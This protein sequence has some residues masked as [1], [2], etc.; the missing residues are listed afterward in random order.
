MRPVRKG[1]KPPEGSPEGVPF[2]EASSRAKR[3]S[4]RAKPGSAERSEAPPRLRRVK[5]GRAKVIGRSPLQKNSKRFHQKAQGNHLF[6]KCLPGCPPRA[7]KSFRFM[8]YGFTITNRLRLLR[9]VIMQE[10]IIII[11]Y[12]WIM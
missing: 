5:R 1:Y 8:V 10:Y 6:L 4:G 12:S 2:S 11:I 9:C 7:G 3:G